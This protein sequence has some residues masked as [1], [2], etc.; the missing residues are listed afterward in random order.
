MNETYKILFFVFA[1]ILLLVFTFLL[2]ISIKHFLV[3]KKQPMFIDK[4]QNK[5]KSI[6]FLIEG[7]IFLFV[8][9]LVL[10]FSIIFLLIPFIY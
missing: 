8:S 4:N 9:L 2:F 6:G 3:Y 7:L 5:S 1:G 10:F